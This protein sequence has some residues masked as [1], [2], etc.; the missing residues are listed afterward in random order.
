M[1]LMKI[2]RTI[3]QVMLGLLF[4]GVPGRPHAQEPE[5]V[6]QI[7][8]PS[9]DAQVRAELAALDRRLN[10]VHSPQL[11]A[12]ILGQLAAT[13]P[14]LAAVA[15]ILADP[16]NN[17]VWEQLPDAY[18]RM[19]LDSGDAL[20][21][22]PDEA[23]RGPAWTSVQ[24]RRLCQQRLTLLPRIALHWYRQRVDAEANALF[25][26][27]RRT[28]SSVPLRRLADELF[29]S[30][31]GDQALDLLGDLAFERGHFDEARHWWSQ[32]APLD[33]LPAD[34]LRFPD[35]K[36][37]LV[38]VQ[39]KQILVLIFQGRLS[40]AQTRIARFQQQHPE[41]KGDLAAESGRYGDVLQK[42]WAAF[43]LSQS[44][45]NDEPWTTFGGDPLRNRVLP[46]AL[47]HLWEDGPTWRVP[48]PSL[49]M[50][51]PRD[52]QL[53]NP[54]R[55]AAFH[56]IIVHQQVLFADHRSVVSY[57]LTTGKE[58]FRFDLRTAG[59]I[60]PGPGVDN[61]ILLP[62]F[63]L[64]ADH[65]RAYVRLG[66]TG[67]G[68]PK[69]GAAPAKPGVQR[70]KN[71]VKAEASYL[72]GLDLTQPEVK[73]PRLLWHVSAPA[74]D[75][76]RTW[77]EGSPL[78][79]DGRVFTALARRAGGR[80]LTSIVCHDTLG[81]QRWARELCDSPDREDAPSAPR[82][83][84]HLLTWTGGQI[85]YCSHAGAIVAVDAWTGQPTWGVRYQ[86]RNS[87]EM[88]LAPPARD[89]A[90][91]L[92]ADSLIYAAPFD[93]DCVFCID[94]QTGRVRWTLE[95]ID[96]VHL[97]G[98]VQ[99]RLVLAT[100]NGVQ[101]VDAATGQSDWT[102][103]SE[104]RLPSLG[105]GLLAGGGLFWPTV[106]ELL[107]YRT[108]TLAAGRQP[109]DPT[110]L[111]TL[112]PGNWAFGH[113]CLAIAGVDE[114]LVYVPPNVTNPPLLGP[115]PQARGVPGFWPLALE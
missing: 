24:V 75:N 33:P 63:T 37:D 62:R 43:T 45:A 15:P 12:S 18:Y 80:V 3:R 112:P 51:L 94:A 10:P 59:L 41:A 72:V 82:D 42:T 1:L 99:G 104:G 64:S 108:L 58:L 83:Q 5:A 93:S 85:V 73:K 34:H 31:V 95:D 87:T 9:L 60:D 88:R 8:L 96:V 17:E 11:A 44:N 28:R 86:P 29:C 100:R 39:A 20:V 84:Q 22:L 16:R 67:V 65:D 19:A 69:E 101:A 76:A 74:V 89:L 35:P 47:A 98:V 109:F 68:P 50:G 77:F 53:L 54:A 57:H 52:S 13:G 90:P 81:R 48:L 25:E 106:D 40:D 114:L 38:R 79:H 97:L 21:T 110:R 49:S 27:G 46:Q 78:V 7:T 105:R 23:N 107:P 14:A 111:S 61:K 32:L 92:C 70:L 4:V 36:V 30:S 103:P 113:G 2:R 91:C 66:A 56:P 26:Q 6:R 55:R 71:R 115:R 102:Q